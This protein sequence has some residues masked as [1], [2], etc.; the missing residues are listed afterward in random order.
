MTLDVDTGKWVES[1]FD[2]QLVADVN[3][4]ITRF[5]F[6]KG[7]S[8]GNNLYV[9]TNE[10]NSRIFKVDALGNV[11]LFSTATTTINAIVFPEAGS[12]FGSSA[13]LGAGDSYWNGNKNI[14]S[15]SAAGVISLFLNGS[16]FIGG[17]MNAIEFAPA[18]SLFGDAMFSQ[19]DGNDSLYK[20]TAAP[21]GTIFAN[22]IPLAVDFMFDKYGSEFDGDLIVS[23]IEKSEHGSFQDKLWRVKSNGAVSLFLDDA[24]NVHNGGGTITDPDGAFQ[25]D[26]YYIDNYWPNASLGG[27]IYRVT[28]EGNRTVFA[29]GFS[30]RDLS[31]V[32]EGPD[33]FLYVA[34][35][36]SGEIYRI[37]PEPGSLVLLAL[38]AAGLISR[39]RR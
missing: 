16:L 28:P 6:S 3:A 11:N 18:G 39:R 21:S 36:Q 27:R 4:P 29:S 35:V 24:S 14:Y 20:F 10:T 12:A 30:V 19:D 8:F 33:G 9:A 2:V 7:G 13:Y 25:G 23:Q 22:G 1:G 31:D 32:V 17:T 26:L 15:C 5:A 38:G 34:D 37:I